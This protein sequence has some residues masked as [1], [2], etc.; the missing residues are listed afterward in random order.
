MTERTQFCTSKVKKHRLLRALLIAAGTI[1][2]VL[3]AIGIFIPLLPATPFLL[4]SAACYMRSSERMHNW[5]MNNRWF[6]RYIKNY[7]EGRGIPLKT[8]VLAISL[9]WLTIF[10]SACFIVHEILLAQVA[11]LVIAVGVSIHLIRTPTFRSQPQK[12]PG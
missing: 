4:L 11:L 2:L 3:G 9:L 10:Y 1:S 8:K 5:L 6:G 12:L 7:Q